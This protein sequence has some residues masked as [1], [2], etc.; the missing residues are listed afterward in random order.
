MILMVLMGNLVEIEMMAVMECQ[1]EME[2]Q[3]MRVGEE[4]LE[5][6]PVLQVNLYLLVILPTTNFLT[7][8]KGTMGL[9]IWHIRFSHKDKM[10]QEVYDQY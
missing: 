10:I 4:A 6:M 9:K 2:H 5:E 7:S 1:E 8:R 3:G